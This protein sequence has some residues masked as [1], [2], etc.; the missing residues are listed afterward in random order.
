MTSPIPLVDLK[1]QYH[2]LRSEIDAAMAAVVE[3][4]AFIN[5]PDVAA[6]EGE[7][8]RFCGAEYC[9][10][11]SSGLE[12]LRLILVAAGIGAGD[13]V[14]VPANTFIATALAVSGV[15]ATVVLADCD[16]RTSNLDLAATRRAITPRTK[17]IIPVHLYGQPVDWAGLEVIATQHGLLL[18]E[19]AAQAHGARVG[20]RQCGSLGLAAAF[21]F[22]PG[23]NLGAFGDAG[24][25][26][27]NDAGLAERIRQARSYGERR[28]YEHTV[29]GG[30]WRLDTLQAAV[31]RVKLR[32]LAV[33][34]ERRRSIAAA[35]TER[36]GDCREVILPHVIAGVTPVWHLYVVEVEKRDRVLKALHQRGVMAGIHYPCPIHLQPAYADLGL[37]EGAFANA[38]LLA[39]RILSLPIFPEMTDAQVDAVCAALRAALAS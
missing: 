30:N 9:V 3:A 27:T 18:I 29:K 2:S 15:G 5:G 36:L 38:E 12:A 10:G 35:Y 16:R 1:A 19:D 24:A 37:A 11:V 23:K 21:S 22:Y 33:W 34:N 31:L 26:T 4:T 13:E 17:A 7:F 8:A 25:V 6:F 32:H 28:K 14:I 39:P 20:P